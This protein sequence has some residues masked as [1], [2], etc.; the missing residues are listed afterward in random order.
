MW[1]IEVDKYI[2]ACQTFH[3]SSNSNVKESYWVYRVLKK[4]K[5][6]KKKISH[7]NY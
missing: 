4:K 3:I 6:K 5:K 1:G 7:I 2:I